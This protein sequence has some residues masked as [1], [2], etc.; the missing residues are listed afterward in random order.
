LRILF[1]VPRYGEEAEGDV[2]AR[3]RALAEGLAARGHEVEVLTTDALDPVT[4]EGVLSPGVGELGRVR[5][6]RFPVEPP[7]EGS[8]TA[9]ATTAIEVLGPVA[10]RL[11]A[12]LR[13]HARDADAVVFF[14]L[15]AWTTGAG[16]ASHPG[17]CVV[18]P[19][20]PL[21]GASFDAIARPAFARARAIAFDTP[22]E[23]DV[24]TY[25]LGRELPAG[26]VVG[27]GVAAGAPVARPTESSAEA[28]RGLGSYVAFAGRLEAQDGCAL[29]V[30]RFLRFQRDGRSRLTLVLLGRGRVELHE[31]PHVRTLGDLPEPEVRSLLGGAR[32]LV[33]PSPREVLAEGALVAWSLGRPLLV[34]ARS[35]VMRR[36]VARVGGG[37]SFRGYDELAACLELLEAEPTLAEAMGQAGRRAV[38]DEHAWATVLLRWEELLERV[39]REGVAA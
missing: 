32:A 22:E 37:L 14:E 9:G 17:R 27:R 8:G 5:V 30:E 34:D 1:V 15:R 26:V 4:W 7:R 11:L 12:H 33:L 20:G 24:A 28:T 29:L 2:P 16:L 31:S 23:R 10:P 38:V 3:S 36:L 39:G 25:R 19:A 21:D 13:R 6:R 35:E 18:V